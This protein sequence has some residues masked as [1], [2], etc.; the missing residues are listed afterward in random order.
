MIYQLSLGD[1]EVV[2]LNTGKCK[3]INN[4][5]VDAI[6]N[7]GEKNPEMN[8]INRCCALVIGL[9]KCTFVYQ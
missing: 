1:G 6:V 2:V 3:D 8:M 5:D 4:D 9:E 7:R